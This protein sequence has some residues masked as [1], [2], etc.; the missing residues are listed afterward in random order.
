MDVTSIPR[1]QT[2]YLRIE[3]ESVDELRAMQTL[4]R[5]GLNTWDQAPKW[6]L[7]VSD[8]VDRTVRV[9]ESV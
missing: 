1:T 2:P 4:L 7:D 3:L 9:L 8:I 5:K 6:L